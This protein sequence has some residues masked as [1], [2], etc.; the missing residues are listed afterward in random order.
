MDEWQEAILKYAQE[1][2]EAGREM[3]FVVIRRFNYRHWKIYLTEIKEQG[4]DKFNEED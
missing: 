2:Y 3:R 4:E 1:A